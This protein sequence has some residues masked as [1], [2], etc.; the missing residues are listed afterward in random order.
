MSL[1]LDGLVKSD[2][3]ELSSDKNGDSIKKSIK[4]VQARL[5]KGGMQDSVEL[6]EELESTAKSGKEKK[7]KQTSWVH[8]AKARATP[9]AA[10]AN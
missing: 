10:K 2:P 1:H 6:E 9:A 8:V 3:K 5:F 7:T 4:A